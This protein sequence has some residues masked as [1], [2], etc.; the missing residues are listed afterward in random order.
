M[1]PGYARLTLKD[2]QDVAATYFPASKAWKFE[3]VPATAK[4]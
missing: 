1:I 2:I 4:P 3:V